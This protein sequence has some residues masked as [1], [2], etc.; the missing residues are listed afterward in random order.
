MRVD[1]ETVPHDLA[2]FTRHPGRELV[3]FKGPP[4]PAAIGGD[5]TKAREPPF[6]GAIPYIDVRNASPHQISEISLDMYAAGILSWD[7]YAMLAFQ[8]ETQPGFDS[9]IGALT[10]EKADPDRPRDFVHIWQ[11]RLAFEH[12][13]NAQDAALIGRTERIVNVLRQIENPTNLLV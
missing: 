7:E 1:P 3:P 12:K 10:G 9:T 4:V 8:A 13:H 2:A 6:G 11:R 5:E